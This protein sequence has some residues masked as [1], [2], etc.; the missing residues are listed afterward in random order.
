MYGK[1]T[2]LQKQG[3]LKLMF[4]DK[5]IQTPKVVDTL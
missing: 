3:S 2:F 4:F 5:F 1:F